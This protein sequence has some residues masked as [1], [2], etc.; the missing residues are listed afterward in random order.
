M[1]RHSHSHT[2]DDHHHAPPADDGEE[3]HIV[4]L[5]PSANTMSRSTHRKHS[6]HSPKHKKHKHGSTNSRS[7]HR[8]HASDSSDTDNTHSPHSRHGSRQGSRHGKK[9]HGTHWYTKEGKGNKGDMG[10]GN[11]YSSDSDFESPSL[12]EK[13]KH[14]PLYKEIISRGCQTHFHSSS[15]V[16]SSSSVVASG[17]GVGVG[18]RDV[19]QLELDVRSLKKRLHVE[20]DLH[21]KTKTEL[22]LIRGQFKGNATEGE[23]GD[24]ENESGT[25]AQDFEQDSTSVVLNDGTAGYPYPSAPPNGQSHSQSPSHSQTPNQTQTQSPSRAKSNE[26]KQRPESGSPQRPSRP[27]EGSQELGTTKRRNSWHSMS[28]QVLQQ[29]QDMIGQEQPVG[30]GGQDQDQEY[31]YSQTHTQT[32]NNGNTPIEYLGESLEGAVVSI[33]AEFESQGR[34]KYIEGRPMSAAR[35]LTQG[36]Q[37]GNEFDMR[38]NNDE[39]D[40]FAYGP[41]DSIVSQASAEELYAYDYG[42]TS[43]NTNGGGGNISPYPDNTSPYPDNTTSHIQVLDVQGQGVQVLD[44]SVQDNIHS[45][46]PQTWSIENADAM[47]FDNRQ[48]FGS[49]VLGAVV[50]M[51]E[52]VMVSIEEGV[53]ELGGFTLY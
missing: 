30:G 20:E 45:Y 5:L 2:P 46:Q 35:G 21:E 24:N 9:S 3:T 14:V 19:Q 17:S 15:H 18:G 42:A 50:G 48:T 13:E 49:E 1:H 7:M 27:S 53:I 40:K 51:P 44:L 41:K 16:S 52:S 33:D 43:G 38:A 10:T 12:K 31:D 6:K 22:A 4:P 11:G 37:R 26:G 8:S 25:Y 34:S 29:D 28:S 39:D 47:E 23:E 36:Q 32:V